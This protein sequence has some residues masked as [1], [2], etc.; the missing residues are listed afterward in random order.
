MKL[1]I[2]PSVKRYATKSLKHIIAQP[3]KLF[4]S[5]IAAKSLNDIPNLKKLSGYKNAY[6]IRI[7]DY[8]AGFLFEDKVIIL[9]RLL[10]RKEV[11]N[12]FPP[13][14]NFLH[15]C[16]HICPALHKG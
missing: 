15:S 2:Q 3:D 5:I 14:S 12:I 13:L 6:R 9:T 10:S 8:R 16:F 7:D 1:K 4:T 11:C